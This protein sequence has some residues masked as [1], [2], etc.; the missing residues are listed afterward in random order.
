MGSSAPSV[1]K[2]TIM[3]PL[4]L[5][6]CLL[7]AATGA[8]QLLVG[9]GVGGQVSHQSVSKPFQGESRSTVQ[10]KDLGSGIASV[11]DSPNRL[12]GARRVVSA[13]VATPVFSS[14]PVVRASPFVQPAPILRS[15]PIVQSAPILRS[16][17]IVQSAPIIHSSPIVQAAPLLRAAPA[18]ADPQAEVSPF[19]YNYAVNDDYS[20]SAFT[21]SE[22][23]DGLRARSGSY[24]VALPDG[25]TQTV[26]YSTDDVNGYVADVSYEGVPSYPQTTAVVAQPA[27]RVAQPAVTVSRPIAVAQPA[28]AVARTPLA[29][30]QPALAVSRP[31][32]S[33]ATPAPSVAR[34]PLAVASPAVVSRPA[35]AVSSPLAVSRPLLG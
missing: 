24:S 33:L 19:S 11:S 27:V 6:L 23:D 4:I 7:A 25:R 10:S 28:V 34:S 5:L 13:P 22:S 35:L 8:P 1:W 17:P 31:T 12:H 2:T 20:G 29:V 32:L 26:T 21:A 14:S 15:S 16:T 30:A 9:A 3:Q 18:L